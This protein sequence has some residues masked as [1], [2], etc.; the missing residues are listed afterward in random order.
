MSSPLPRPIAGSPGL[1]GDAASLLLGPAAPARLRR[2]GGLGQVDR[3][4]RRSGRVGRGQREQ[5]R[6]EPCQSQRLGLGGGQVLPH[7]GV[8]VGHVGRLDAQAKP[9][10]RRAQLM[11]RVGHELALRVEGV[12]EPVGHGVECACDILLLRRPLDGCARFEIAPADAPGGRCQV[13]QRPCQRAGHE[14]GD[15]EPERERQGADAHE[16]VL[17][18]ADFPVEC[19]HALGDPHG[20]G[21]TALL[22]D[23]YGRVEQLLVERVRASPALDG[24]SLERVDDLG[25]VAVVDVP[26]PRL[27]RVG[28]QRARRPDDQHPGAEIA[29][30]PAYERVELDRAAEPARCAG[31][32]ELRPVRGLRAHLAVDT[33]LRGEGQRHREG[34]DHEHEDVREGRE[35]TR[36]VGH[37]LSSSADAKRNPTPRTVCR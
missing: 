34:H 19:G 1:D 23:R 4:A 24:A 6:D 16:R 25:A 35:Q 2:A 10:Q 28:Q 14:P 13:P 21:R 18:P 29:G 7:L 22:D 9:R 3:R 20:S 5:V 8:G 37:S 17:I 27:R 33:V 30:D 26:G 12:R 32:D 36:A 11:R 15:G 31:G